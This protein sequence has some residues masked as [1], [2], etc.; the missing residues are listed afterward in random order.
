MKGNDGY[1]QKY[2]DGWADGK[3][4]IGE[5]VDDKKEGKRIMTWP[6]GDCY[7]MKSI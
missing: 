3:K 2:E 6:S 7:G 5:F 4:Y 1:P